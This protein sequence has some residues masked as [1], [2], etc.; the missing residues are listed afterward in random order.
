[1]HSAAKG[2]VAGRKHRTNNSVQLEIISTVQF[3]RQK[4]IFGQVG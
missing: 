2:T 4:L 3:V 1:M